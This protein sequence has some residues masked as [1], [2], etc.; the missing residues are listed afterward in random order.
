MMFVGFDVIAQTANEIDLHP[1]L[2]GRLIIVSVT[3]AMLF[4]ATAVFCVGLVLGDSASLEEFPT[5]HAAALGW[6]GREG[7][8]YLIIIGGIA[9]ILTSWNGF[10]VGASRLVI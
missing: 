5:A 8:R 9:G 4:Y 1:R 6:D 7:V 10:L 3:A 2:I